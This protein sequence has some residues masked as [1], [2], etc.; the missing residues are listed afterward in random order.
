[1][2][3]LLGITRGSLFVPV[4]TYV[5]WSDKHTSED[6]KL[7]CVYNTSDKQDYITF[8]NNFL[9][10]HTR[11]CEYIKVDDTTSVFVF[12]FSDIKSDWAHFSNGRYSKINDKQKRKILNYFKDNSANYFYVKSYLFPQKYWDNYA[13]LLNVSPFLLEEVGE[14]CDKPDLIKENLS[15]KVINL[16]VMN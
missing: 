12:D 1:M 15:I 9:I 8:E 14:L 6:A 7:V 2:Y 3:P 4:E 13:E 10:K 16:A 11:V 5:S